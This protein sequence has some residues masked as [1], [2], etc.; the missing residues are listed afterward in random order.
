LQSNLSRTEAEIDAMPWTEARGWFDCWRAFP[1]PSES[2]ARIAAG[3]GVWK[4]PDEAKPKAAVS[5]EQEL[6]AFAMFAR[7]GLG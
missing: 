6:L 3:L 5:S 7:G 2:L 1:P 4:A